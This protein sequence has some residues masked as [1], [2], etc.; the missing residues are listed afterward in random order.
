[1]LLVGLVSIRSFGK[2]AFIK[3]RDQSGDVQLYLQK[4]DVAELDASRGVLGMKQLKLLD[5]GDFVQATGEMTTTQTGEKSV[6]VRE[7]RLLT[8]A[9]T[10]S[11]R[12]AD[13]Q[14]R[15]YAPPLRRYERK[16]RGARAICS[17]Q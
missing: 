4:D 6:G 11:P 10:T 2:L 12:G 16:P 15:A 14:R 9:L 7:L 13:Q 1:M 3:I 17:S 5:T 8:K